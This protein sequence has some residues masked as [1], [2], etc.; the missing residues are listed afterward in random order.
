[1]STRQEVNEMIV[2]MEKGLAETEQAAGMSRGV[3]NDVAAL[4]IPMQ[5]DQLA[6]LRKIA[7]GLPD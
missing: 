5:R 7:E 1:M 6:I 2:T 4:V 3:L